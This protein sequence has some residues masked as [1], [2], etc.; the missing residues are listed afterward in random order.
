MT[1][2][3]SLPETLSSACLEGMAS[4]AGECFA[5]MDAD[6]QHDERILPQMIS[7]LAD[8]PNLEAIG[9]GRE[10]E[11]LR[12]G[13]ETPVKLLYH[14]MMSSHLLPL[15]DIVEHG[16]EGVDALWLFEVGER[17][18][19]TLAFYGVGMGDIFERFAQ[20]FVH[21]LSSNR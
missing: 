7:A 6:L 4:S 2:G 3:G 10:A 12:D 18:C 1:K 20:C 21:S 19:H 5:V 16:D 13:L 14:T 17:F 8:D 9:T 11:V 15:I